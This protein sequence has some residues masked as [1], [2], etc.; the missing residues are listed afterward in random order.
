MRHSITSVTRSASAGDLPEKVFDQSLSEDA[1]LEKLGYEQELKRS[2]GLFGMIGFSFS[3]VTCWTALGGVLIVG[4]E[5]GGAPVMIYGWIGVCLVA[6]A[7][8][9]SMAEMCSAYP[10]AG[11]QYSWVAILAP[12]KWARGLSYVC[13]W[14]MVIGILAMGAVNNFIGSN[15]ILGMAQLTHPDTY[16]IERWHVSLLAYL[17]AFGACASNIF[18]PHLLDKISRGILLWNI[19]SFFVVIIT[20]LATNDHKQPAHFVFSDFQNF[21]GFGNSYT[22]VLGILQSA[23][24]MCC[25]DAPAHMTEEMKDARKSA[26]KAIVYS[27][28]IG[29]FTGLVFLISACF[30]IGDIDTVATTP[31]GTPLIQIFFDS[32]GSRGGSCALASLITVIVI[33]CANSLMAEGGRA[34]WAFARDGGLPF[35]SILK[36]VE[37][38]RQVPVYAILFTMV[39]QMAFN[40]I[41]FGTVT[42]FTTVISIAT[43]GFYVSYA[44]P[45]L[46]RILSRITNSYTH[47]PGP[48]SLGRYGLILNIVGFLYL[49]FAVVIFNLPTL[50]PVTSENMNY[51]CAAIGAIMLIAA[52]TWILTGRKHFSGPEGGK[53]MDA[54]HGEGTVLEGMPDRSSVA[55]EVQEE[56]KA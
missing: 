42:G 36:K 30:C 40:S 16:T 43:E 18:L 6:L 37:K 11:G 38:K 29:A 12:Q 53:I 32:T 44:I 23:F 45:L 8:A 2:F 52:V 19:A 5:S 39:V 13:G 4:V 24:G 50:S 20:I 9:Y 22:A 14:F 25:Y 35:S 46:A 3:I 7:V 41:Y 21:T 27:V 54:R 49:M 47:L 17:F 31:T 34:V 1:A 33:F 10:V 56:K 51:T 55:P 15:F 26:P 28:Y 48:Y